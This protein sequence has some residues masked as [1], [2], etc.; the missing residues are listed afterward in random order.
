[1][2]SMTWLLQT[3]PLAK[4][5]AYSFKVDVTIQEAEAQRSDK[6]CRGPAD[7]T[8]W[9]LRRKPT[10]SSLQLRNP[11]R[12]CHE[13]NQT[14]SLL[15]VRDMGP[16]TRAGAPAWPLLFCVVPWLGGQPQHSRH[17]E[18]LPL[19]AMVLPVVSH[20]PPSLCRVAMGRC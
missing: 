14:G 10:C 17:P 6:T 19:E 7:G 18:G 1:M 16:L 8:G 13:D 3:H 15:G 11:P 5:S 9:G 2:P 20:R 4:S 12:R